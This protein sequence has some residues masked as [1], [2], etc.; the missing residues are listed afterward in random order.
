MKTAVRAVAAL[1]R[2]LGLGL[3]ILIVFGCRSPLESGKSQSLHDN[4]AR[5]IARE[6]ET[7]PLTPDHG[8]TQPGNL[9]LART[10]SDVLRELAPRRE[11]LEAIGPL[12]Q[13]SEPVLDLGADLI[14]SEQGRVDIT[15]E[16]AIA[17]AVDRNLAIQESRLQPAISAE[18]LI[19]AQ[20][21]FDFVLFG[22]VDLIKTDQPQFVPVLNGIPLGTPFS[23]DE[24]YR[25]E[26][27][28]RKRLNLGTDIF[29]STDLTRFRNNA[30]GISFSPDPAYTGAV[31][32]GVN[33][34]LLRGFG[35]N[36]NT[37]TIRI[38][39]NQ[40]QRSASQVERDLL[41]LVADTE[42][43]YWN[44]QQSWRNL[45]IAEWLLDVGVA[46]RE[47]LAARRELDVTSAQYSDAVARVEQRRADVIRARRAVRSASDTLKQI[48]ND[49][50]LT[51]SSE[52]VLFPIDAASESPI[53]Y[54]LR[55]AILT[56]I[57]RRPEIRQA[58]LNIDDASI[59][60]EVARIDELPLLDASAQ[61]AWFGLDDDP[62]GA[63]GNLSDNDF[64]DYI[65]GLSFEYPLGNRGAE[66]GFRAARL[67]RSAAA[68]A[69]LRTVQNV[70]VEV[71]SALRNVITNY[72]L[73]EATRAF[74][75]AQAEN[76]RALQVQED[77]MMGLTP[78]FL[79][80]KFQRQETLAEAKRQEIAALVNFDNALA[81]LYRAMGVGL[82]MKQLD[83]EIVGSDES[84]GYLNASD[85]GA[86]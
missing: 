53:T 54:N 7:A 18:E 47:K 42:T 25:F 2:G 22:N 60:Q 46:V 65:L 9:S 61:M 56:A 43:A 75:V 51:V 59:R 32:L 31:R 29:A 1:G 12:A 49:P 36:V 74:R 78:E 80:L 83:I 11:E 4:V 39:R 24:T 3:A 8:G 13:G 21:I 68:L 50:E 10:E 23:A 63:Y 70:I 58:A 76:L 20:A 45:A 48:V 33:Q 17:M 67:R 28:V 38:A 55:E 19:G 84:D 40:R 64:I 34:P 41:A 66:A 52:A 5:A 73:I 85:P 6:L 69:Y 86:Q 37:A 14:G 71:K 44:L 77:T 30:P 79:N 26:T 35:T 62:G 81:E 57:D 72:E 82:T 16:R 27:G 15:L